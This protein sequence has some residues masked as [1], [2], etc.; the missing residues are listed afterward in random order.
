MI[1]K[2]FG[3][4]SALITAIIQ[5]DLRR[6]ESLVSQGA[7][8]NAPDNKGWRPLHAAIS[9]ADF[10]RSIEFVKLL[11]KHGAN[12]N[13]WDVN[14]NDTPI[15]CACD[16]PNLAMARVLLEAGADPNALR[17]DGES[18]LRLCA[19]AKDLEMAKLLLQHG[20][21]KTIDEFGGV[22]AW[23]ALSHA[24]SNFDIPMIELLLREGANPETPG[25]Y[26]ETARDNLPPREEHD[27]QT[28]DRVIELLGRRMP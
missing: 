8:P 26:D 18:P 16:P 14:H 25:E 12:V 13:E 21:G 17:S 23:T 11:L 1:F 6:V 15:L 22:L 9:Q 5:R 4:S 2:K 27:P 24:A 7:D 3:T 19:A 28:W 20:A 10:E